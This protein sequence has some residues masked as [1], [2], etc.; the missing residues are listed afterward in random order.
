MQS[1]EAPRQFEPEITNE[2]FIQNLVKAGRVPLFGNAGTVY[3]I[4]SFGVV[5]SRP[6]VVCYIPPEGIQAEDYPVSHEGGSVEYLSPNG[7]SRGYAEP[8]ILRPME[9]TL[10]QT[11]IDR[12]QAKLAKTQQGAA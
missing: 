8:H 9:A 3:E 12:A 6:V 5:K 1:I 10:M 11:R 4:I 7:R 2:G